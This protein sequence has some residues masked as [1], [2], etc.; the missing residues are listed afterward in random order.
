MYGD[1][2]RG[3]V[4]RA[5]LDSRRCHAMCGQ[6][7]DFGAASSLLRLAANELSA[8]ADGDGMGGRG[9]GGAGVGASNYFA[10]SSLKKAPHRHADHRHSD[11]AGAAGAAAAERALDWVRQ[12]ADAECRV[13]VAATHEMRAVRAEADVFQL[14]PRALRRRVDDVMGTSAL[15]RVSSEAA[16]SHADGLPPVHPN[17]A[18]ALGNEHQGGLN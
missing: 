13:L 15:A 5:I 12:L 2:D 11:G 7:V 1:A 10:V 16:D 18:V 4:E 17:P 9:G 6:P 8:A 3:V 14:T